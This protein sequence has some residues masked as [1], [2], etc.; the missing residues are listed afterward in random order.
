MHKFRTGSLCRQLL[1]FGRRIEHIAGLIEENKF[2][3][4]LR[5]RG[6]LVPATSPY[7]F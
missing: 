4:G 5:G 7:L 6:Q 2:P 1:F 3:F